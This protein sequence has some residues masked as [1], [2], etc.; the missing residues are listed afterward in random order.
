MKTKWNILMIAIATSIVF[1]VILLTNDVNQLYHI[2]IDSKKIW[3]LLAIFC[4]AIYCILE[5][6]V[7][8]YTANSVRNKLSFIKAFQTTMVGLLF[9][10]ITPF[11]SGGQPAQLYY[12]TQAS[13][14]LG[15]ASSIL[16]MKLIVYQT[17]LIL[18]SFVL[19]FVRYS[20]FRSHVSTLGYLITLGFVVNVLVVSGLLL[21]GFL[22]TFTTKLCRGLI[23][24]LAKIHIIKNKDASTQKTIHQIQEFH[25]VFRVLLSQKWILLN[26]VVITTLQHTAFFFIPFCICM[27][28]GIEM[29]SVL[30]V[31]AASAF[32]LLISSFVPL[33]GASGGAEGS[34]YLLFGIFLIQPGITAVALI[35]W[36]LITYYLPIIV[37]LCFCRIKA[38]N[39]SEI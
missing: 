31:L 13:F 25:D 34:F 28:L 6:G 24:I 14:Q 11:A 2:F 35:L 10:N 1:G 4:M 16:L 37:G 9:N 21:I 15:E 12:L 7:L 27:A 23:H 3:L 33:P 36:R 5:S 17:S 26:S 38:A 18:Y 8:Y 30:S 20:F 39:A 29:I 19:L 32:V 22:P